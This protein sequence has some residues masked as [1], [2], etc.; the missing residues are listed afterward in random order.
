MHL[1]L[2]PFFAPQ[3]VAIIGA[4][5]TPNKLSF[6]IVRNMTLYGYQGHIAPVNPKVN[7]ILGLQCYPDIFSVP[8]PVDLAVIV[9]P[10]P[11]IP[12]VVEACGRRGIQAVTIISGGFKEIGSGGASLEQQILEIAKALSNAS[13]RTQLRRHP[14]FVYRPEYH[15]YPGCPRKRRDRFCIPIGRGW[16]WSGGLYS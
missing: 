2:K 4:S 3:G 13:D 9:L 1:S 12:E 8:D 7:E 16:R 11:A 14:R 10:A 15:V 6:G 5:A